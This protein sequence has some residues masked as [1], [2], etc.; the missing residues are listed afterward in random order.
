LII[1]ALDTTSDQA[2]VAVLRNT[3]PTVA[4]SSARPQELARGV[5]IWEEVVSTS[6]GHS[7][8]LYQMIESV[9]LQAA[10]SVLEVDCF[11]SARGPGSFTGTRICL[12]AAK[13]LAEATGKP[14]YGVSNLRALASFG[15]AA[16]RNPILDARRGQIYTAIFNSNLELVAPEIVTAAELWSVAP[17][18]EQIRT[19]YPLASAVALCAELDGPSRWQDPAELDAHYVRRADSDK[20]WQ[21]KG[22]R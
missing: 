14:A 15:T 21:D 6:D 8:L 16:L 10:V 19:R 11:A 13:G 17:E 12:A 22:A 4:V 20:M 3:R 2:S 9:L 18:V 1:L 5:T 7:Y